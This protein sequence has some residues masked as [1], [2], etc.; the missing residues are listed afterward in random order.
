MSLCLRGARLTLFAAF[1]LVLAGCS[2]STVRTTEVTPV[3]TGDPATPESELLDV[4]I[5]LFDPNA[6][7]LTEDEIFT[8]PEIRKAEARYMPTVLA[9][10]VQKSGHWGAVRVTPTETGVSDVVVAGRILESTGE[11]LALEI[12]VSD[13]SGAAWY[14]RAYEGFA[15]KYSYQGKRAPE[16]FQDVYNRIANDLAIA[17]AKLTPAQAVRLRTISE[18]RFAQGFAPKAFGGFLDV[19]KKG[20]VTVRRLPAENDPMLERIRRI[21]ERD[22]L[23]VDT[24]QDFYTGFSKQMYGPYQDWRKESYTES[25]AYRE[26]RAQATGRTIAGVASILA[27]IAAQTGDS[28]ATRAAGTVGIVGGA[29][30]VKSG[31]DKRAESKMHAETLKELGGSLGAEIEPQVIELEDRSVTLTGSVQDQY[32]Q[33]REIL[34]GIYDAETGS[35]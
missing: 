10:T 21:R 24:L 6:A 15:S 23:F 17:R 25:I 3:I 26:L 7:T 31:F 29:A 12:S 35:I 20:R 9:D 18:L 1:A 13:A 14:T 22:N 4:G 27:G 11:K 8:S 32:G 33:W 34:R 16:P 30:M 19:D 2:S 5:R 28:A